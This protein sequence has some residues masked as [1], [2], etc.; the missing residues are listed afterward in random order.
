MRQLYEVREDI[1]SKLLQAYVRR[2][3]RS[4]V[5]SSSRAAAGAAIVNFLL[6]DKDHKPQIMVLQCVGLSITFACKAS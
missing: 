4:A 1:D 3:S 6:K 2:G 5:G